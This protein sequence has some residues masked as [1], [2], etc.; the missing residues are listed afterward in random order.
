LQQ[1]LHKILNQLF[2][3]SRLLKI[4]WNQNK[5]MLSGFRSD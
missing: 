1:N 5:V 2:N 3:Q 4:N